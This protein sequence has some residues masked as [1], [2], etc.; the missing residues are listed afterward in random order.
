MTTAKKADKAAAQKGSGQA[1]TSNVCGTAAG[2]GSSSATATQ[3]EN[4]RSIGGTGSAKTD[5]NRPGHK[6][7]G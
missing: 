7:T 6:A 4:Q 3:Q 2:P 5:R 1:G